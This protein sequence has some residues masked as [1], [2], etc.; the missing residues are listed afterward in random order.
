MR[1]WRRTKTKRPRDRGVAAVELALCMFVLV[2]LMLGTIDYGYYFYVAEN[3]VE[4]Q[5]AGATAAS[6]TSIGGTCSASSAQLAAATLAATSAMTVYM[7]NVGSSLSGVTLSNTTPT[8]VTTTSTPSVA[9]WQ[10]GIGADFT[11]IIGWVAPWMKSTTAG[12]AHYNAPALVV[13]AF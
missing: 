4:A 9:T 2:P 12:K 10:F 13:R 8:C 1:W 11:P 3:V 5:Q 6:R 7:A